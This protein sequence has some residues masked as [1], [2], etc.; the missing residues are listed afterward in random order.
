MDSGTFSSFKMNAD[1]TKKILDARAAKLAVV[2]RAESSNSEKR[3]YLSFVCGGFSFLLQSEY[4]D[5][6]I[7]YKEVTS[8]PGV[9]KKLAGIFNFRGSILGVYDGG[10]LLNGKNDETTSK[11]YIIVCSLKNIQFAI[12]C[13]EITGIQNRSLS[14]LLEN[15]SNELL[16]SII[17][18][19]FDDSAR[20]I[21]FEKLVKDESL[22]IL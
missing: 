18:G 10:Y 2:R 19:V 8:L 16:P 1:Q 9:D 12:S 7:R 20:C 13:E 17:M 22:K 4:V 15:S 6:V 3:E 21:D 11:H 5:E 14:D